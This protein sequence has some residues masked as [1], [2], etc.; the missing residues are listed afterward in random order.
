MTY[1]Y[2]VRER[3][4]PGICEWLSD[5]VKGKY[6]ITAVVLDNENMLVSLTVEF[7]RSQD[8]WNFRTLRL[9]VDLFRE[10]WNRR[11]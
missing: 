3:I 8:A 9:P 10:R 4:E 6:E 1:G 11:F 7:Q 2:Y 5:K